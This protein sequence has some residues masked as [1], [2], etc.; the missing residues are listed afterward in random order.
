MLRGLEESRRPRIGNCSLFEKPRRML[1]LQKLLDALTK[2]TGAPA[3]VEDFGL[4]QRN[5]NGAWPDIVCCG[6]NICKACI[7]IGFHAPSMGLLL[8]SRALAASSQLL[9]SCPSGNMIGLSG[10][11]LAGS[12]SP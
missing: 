7:Q 4:V 11:I 8:R 3:N 1:Y 2:W 12:A 5:F 10:W 6:V 9:T